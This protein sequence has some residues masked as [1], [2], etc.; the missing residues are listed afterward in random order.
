MIN[1]GII[2]KVDDLGRI[3]IPVEIRND[4]DIEVGDSMAIHVEG[5][6]IIFKKYMCKCNFCGNTENLEEFKEK[7]I[8]Q[9]CKNSLN[10]NETA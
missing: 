6:S 5:T 4:L 10:N 8:C 1:T 7:L 3:V 9:E 2:R